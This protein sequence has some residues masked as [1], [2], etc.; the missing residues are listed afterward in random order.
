VEDCWRDDADETL[1]WSEADGLLE[2][3]RSNVFVWDGSR[4]STPPAVGIVPGVVREALLDRAGR[5]GIA[6]DERPV[7]LC[8]LSEC[9][10]LFLSGTGLG[11]VRV[12]RLGGRQLE[13]TAAGDLESAC[14]R[15]LETETEGGGR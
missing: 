4:L 12:D 13:G 9:R 7:S 15:L 3:T 11:F 8:E 14:R 2:G 6:V 5:D 10:A 1:L